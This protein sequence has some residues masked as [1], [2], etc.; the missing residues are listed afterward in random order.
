M[1]KLSTSRILPTDK[2]VS[3]PGNIVARLAEHPDKSDTRVG[4][5]AHDLNRIAVAGIHLEH[6]QPVCIRMLFGFQ[7]LRDPERLEPV[8]AVGNF[9]DLQPDHRQTFDDLFQAGIGFQV[10]L[11]PGKG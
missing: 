6:A 8:G 2:V 9:L 5:A 10:L 1:P 4:R 11:E 3:R 7:H